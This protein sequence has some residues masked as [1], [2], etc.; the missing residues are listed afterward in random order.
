MT[1]KLAG[2]NFDFGH[3][4]ILLVRVS[5]EGQD[6]QPQINDL[7][8]YAKSKGYTVLHHIQTKESG[9][10]EAKNRQGT[11]ELFEFV[12]NNPEYR[13]VFSTE[14]SRLGRRESDIHVIKDWFIKNKVQFH[15]KDRRYQLFDE[16]GVLIDDILFTLYGYFAESEIKQKKD[17]FARAKRSLAKAGYCVSGKRLF[18]YDK[19]LAEN[20]KYRYVINKEEATVIDQIYR[21][22]LI[23]LDDENKNPSIKQITLMCRAKNFPVYT[24]SKRNVNKLLKEKAYTGFKITNNKRKNPGFKYDP[25]QSE[26]ITTS[27]EIHY[28]RIVDDVT[29]ESIQKKLLQNNTKDEKSSKHITLLSRLITCNL[30][31]RA[32]QGEYRTVEGLNKN[33]YRCSAVKNPDP[34]ENKQSI[35]MVLLDSAVWSLIKLDFN[36]LANQIVLKTPDA[37]INILSGEQ[38]VLEEKIASIEKE[39]KIENGRISI[40]SSK[41][42][43]DIGEMLTGFEKKID[44]LDKDLGKSKNKLAQVANKIEQFNRRKDINITELFQSDIDQIEQDKSLLKRYINT[45]VRNIN[46]LFQNN[47]YSVISVNFHYSVVSKKKIAIG[48]RMKIESPLGKGTCIFID[49]SNTNNIKVVKTNWLPVSFEDGFTFYQRDENSMSKI[50][51]IKIGYEE[52]FTP[53][54]ATQSKIKEFEKVREITQ[55]FQPIPFKKL[56]VY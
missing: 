14:M 50:K 18:G 1:Q 12:K 9:L 19:E 10:I 28:P 40:L 25:Q 4:A 17:R 27:M 53:S 42:N 44:K 3:H 55:L 51:K 5:T 34:C 41:K 24:H 48:E 22:Y 32:I 16:N 49:K 29:F 56:T 54:Q 15:L 33:F 31:G 20:K 11:N 7:E 38:K 47:R 21:W 46:I 30:C 43:I 2:K 13:T 39:I 35:G 8:E 23:G 6:L 26:H 37:E 52:V 45:F 36:S